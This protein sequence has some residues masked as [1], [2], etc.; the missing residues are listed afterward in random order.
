V[1]T[2]DLEKL[3]RLS[4]DS[5]VL[6]LASAL[7]SASESPDIEQ[8]EAFLYMLLNPAEARQIPAYSSLGQNYPNPFNPETW[9]PYQ[10]AKGSEVTIE[11][12]NISGQLVRTMSLGYRDAGIYITK[13]KAAYWDG[14]SNFGEPV[15]SGIYFYTIKAG[16]FTNTRKL[17][18]VR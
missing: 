15:S 3:E 1:A 12:Y 16:D 10:L 7:N 11:I 2:A 4:G 5:G 18:V 14:R 9:I 17:I 8:L 13:Q 6:K